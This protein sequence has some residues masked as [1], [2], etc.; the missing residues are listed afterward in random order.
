MYKSVFLSN[1]SWCC[2]YSG[3]LYSPEITVITI[4]DQMSNTTTIQQCFIVHIQVRALG[5]NHN[6]AAISS[7]PQD[8][9]S[10]LKFEFFEAT[11]FC[12]VQFT[13]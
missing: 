7:L 10:F 11:F 4:V 8:R 9:F 3:L 13:L 6:M 2:L 1:F 12:S 5:N